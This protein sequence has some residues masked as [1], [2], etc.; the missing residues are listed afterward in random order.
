MQWLKH[1]KNIF[2]QLK[3]YKLIVMFIIWYHKF[4]DDVL[5]YICKAIIV[6]LKLR[7]S[8]HVNFCF[9]FPQGVILHTIQW[10][11]YATLLERLDYCVNIYWV[12]FTPRECKNTYIISCHNIQF[13]DVHAPCLL[14]LFQASANLWSLFL[15]H[16]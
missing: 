2:K 1:F 12:W 11:W 8:R 13:V 14:H 15:V 7:I 4:V 6:W 9:F 5:W 10:I 3:S 16:I